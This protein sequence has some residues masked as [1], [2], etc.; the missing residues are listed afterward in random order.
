MASPGSVTADAAPAPA[1][2][3]A[4][5][6]KR[7]RKRRVVG[8]IENAEDMEAKHPALFALLPP[9]DQLPGFNMTTVF[10]TEDFKVRT[11]NRELRVLLVVPLLTPGRPRR[12]SW[13]S[14]GT[15]RCASWP[16]C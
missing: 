4:P 2:A 6:S 12:C 16:A 11:N 10:T 9:K 13:A 1:P 3:P 7:A 8:G 15:W 14:G 5:T